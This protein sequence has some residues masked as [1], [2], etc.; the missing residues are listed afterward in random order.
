MR[1][2]ITTKTEKEINS[3]TRKGFKPIIRQIM[4]SNE[5]RSKYKLLQNEKTG[6]IKTISDFRADLR[7]PNWI[8]AIGWT[9]YY[10]YQ[11]KLPFAAYLV[12]KD[13]QIGERVILT[14]LIEDFVGARWN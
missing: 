4:P 5:I 14:D 9:Y 6:E 8:E 12:P 3:A 10:P 1:R 13:I 2:I 11:F 7:D